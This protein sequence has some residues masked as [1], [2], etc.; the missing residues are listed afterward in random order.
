MKFWQNKCLPDPPLIVIGDS[1]MLPLWELSF[2]PTCSMQWT[3]HRRKGL[4]AG[5]PLSQLKSISLPCIKAPSGMPLLYAT[6]VNSHTSQLIM[7]VAPFSP[8]IIQYPVPKVD[9]PMIWHNEIKDFTAYLMLEVF[10]DVSV[11][12]ALQPL[13]GEK[14]SGAI[15]NREDKARLDLS[16]KGFCGSRNERAFFDVRIFYPSA[17]SNIKSLWAAPTRNTKVRRGEHMVNT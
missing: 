11:E 3:Y 16:A 9:S 12:P 13:S 1:G 17:P 14:L 10:H 7:H 8:S 4:Q 15:A 5:L 6:V 2:P